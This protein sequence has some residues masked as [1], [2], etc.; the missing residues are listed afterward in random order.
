MTSQYKMKLNFHLE[1]YD[2][3]TVASVREDIEYIILNYGSHPAFYRTTGKKKTDKSL[4]LFYIYDSYRIPPNEWLAITDV[5]GSATIRN[6][7]LDSLLIGNFSLLEEK[8]FYFI[9]LIFKEN[10]SLDVS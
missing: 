9:F 6:T 1:P 4:P 2:S 5:N 10:Y 3:R 8:C 7:N